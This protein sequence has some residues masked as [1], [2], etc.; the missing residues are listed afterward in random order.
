MNNTQIEVYM[1]FLVL[2]EVL[3][4]VIF[5]VV[6]ISSLNILVFNTYDFFERTMMEWF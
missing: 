4:S 5:R 1:Y 6:I 3:K 2:K